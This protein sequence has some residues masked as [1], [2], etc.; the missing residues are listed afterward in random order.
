MCPEEKHLADPDGR[1]E[2]C[3]DDESACDA[4]SDCDTGGDC[5]TA[6]CV[7]ASGTGVFACTQECRQPD[8]TDASCGPGFVCQSAQD[9][10]IAH[11]VPD[12]VECPEGTIPADPDGSGTFV[13][14]REDSGCFAPSDCAPDPT[15][16]CVGACTEGSDDLWVCVQSCDGDGER[17]EGDMWECTSDADCDA[18][19]GGVGWTCVT[20]CS[21]N[22]CEP[23]AACVTADDCALAINT[24]DCCGGCAQAVP[25]SVLGEGCWVE[26]YGYD[27]DADPPGGGAEPV[28]PQDECTPDCRDVMCPLWECAQPAGVDC[29]GGTCVPMG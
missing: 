5:C 20:G 1:G 6:S 3:I 9:E 28:P 25:R 15:G 24:N 19:M 12:D 13:C 16:C 7:D 23:P 8:C 17:D 4:P 18:G 11:C 21:G 2:R 14:V 27:S 10:C 22:Y 26:Y 29:Q